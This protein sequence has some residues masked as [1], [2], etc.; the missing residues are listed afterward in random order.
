MFAVALALTGIPVARTTLGQGSENWLFACYGSLLAIAAMALVRSG[1]W[2]RRAAALDVG[3]DAVAA[4]DDLL[5]E[6]IGDP[7]AHAVVHVEED[8]W[9]RLDG[10]PEAAPGASSESVVVVSSRT[11]PTALKES[12]DEGL[13]LAGDNVLARRLVDARARE[14]AAVRTRLVWVEEEERAGLVAHLRR[15]PLSA[16]VELGASLAGGGAREALLEHVRDTERDLERVATGLDPLDGFGSVAGA[17][18][19][20]CEQLGASSDIDLEVSLDGMQGRA[21]WYACSE[22]LTNS[23]KHA[24]DSF[25]HV[26]LVSESSWVILVVSDDGPGPGAALDAGLLGVRDRLAAVGGTLSVTH[27]LPGTRVEASVPTTRRHL[28]RSGVPPDA[29]DPSTFLA[30]KPPTQEASP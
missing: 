3:P 10:R 26:R 30:L 20:L 4:L 23:A 25:R 13:R 19:G 8:H 29:P 17:V 6:V 22:A 28:P 9:V 16:L 11:V 21:L 14:L 12:V 15:G 18:R 24:V 7:R 2:L 5:A 27:A 1:P